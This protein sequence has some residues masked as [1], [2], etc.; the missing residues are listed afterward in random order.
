[1]AELFNRAEPSDIVF[2]VA[3]F[4]PAQYKLLLGE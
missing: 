3:H 4:G 2:L 1:M